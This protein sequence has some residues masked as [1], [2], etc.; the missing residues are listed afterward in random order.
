MVVLIIVYSETYFVHWLS[1]PVPVTMFCSL[2]EPTSTCN[3][4]I[5]SVYREP[6]VLADCKF[7]TDVEKETLMTNIKHRLTPHP[8]KIRAGLSTLKTVFHLQGESSWYLG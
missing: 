2:V 3:H 6:D 7:E 1:L 8:V 5:I 4:V